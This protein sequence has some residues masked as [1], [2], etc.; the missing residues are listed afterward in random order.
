[1]HYYQHDFKYEPRSVAIL[2][3]LGVYQ[4]GVA[5]TLINEKPVVASV[6]EVSIYTVTGC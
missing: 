4:D 1:M 2:K 6:Y 3:K 5:K